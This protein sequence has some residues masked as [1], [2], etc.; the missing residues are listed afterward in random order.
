VA[1]LA[2]AGLLAAITFQPLPA[3]PGWV[4]LAYLRIEHDL[5]LAG[6]VVAGAAGT[7]VGRTAWAAT[8]RVVGTRLLR[9]RYRA[10][11]EY[12]A[13]RLRGRHGRLGAF[14]LLAASPPPS[15][16]VYTAAGL[17]R[18]NLGLVAGAAFAGRLV[19]YGVM[20]AATG[21]LASE[22][23]DR[24]RGGFGPWWI[25]LTA[26]LVATLVLLV[27]LD[28]RRLLEAGRRRRPAAD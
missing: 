11:V 23:V 28:W 27:R 12:L 25:V 18:I 13:E 24:L 8:A 7:A 2:I 14:G 26:A 15:G 5:D 4:V 17:L 10:N 9:G 19:S 16:A 22:L 3:P 20:V 21:A 6:V 1:Y